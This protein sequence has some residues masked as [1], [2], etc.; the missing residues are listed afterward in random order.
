M[1][2]GRIAGSVKFVIVGLGFL[3]FIGSANAAVLA[4]PTDYVLVYDDLY[5][6]AGTTSNVLKQYLKLRSEGQHVLLLDA[7][8]L[9]AD[10]INKGSTIV[11]AAS[12]FD[13]EQK[14]Q[15]TLDDLSGMDVIILEDE[16]IK[17]QQERERQELIIAIDKVYPFSD[18]NKLMD[19]AE[20]LYDRGMNF[21]VTV[22]PVYENYEL[23][24]FETYIRIL[25]YVGDKGG[26]FFIRYPVENPDGTY[27]TDPR[28]G[29]RR[30]VDEYRKQGLKIIGITLPMDKL[31]TGTE[32]FE[33][34][35]LPLVMV[36]D[37]E[38]KIGSDFDLTKISDMLNRYLIIEG[39]EIND[40]DYFRYFE[41]SSASGSQAVNLSLTD[42]PEKLTDLLNVFKF[43]KMPIGDFNVEDF[44]DRLDNSW[45]AKDPGVQTEEREKSQLEVFKEEE[46]RK[47]R[48]EN[49][50]EEESI[51][52]YDI[53]RFVNKGIMI[54]LILLVLLIVQVLAGRYFELKKYYKD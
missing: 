20:M 43:Y 15:K 54:A 42:D 27:N 34:L 38:N 6:Y 53:S 45:H 4:K 52:G 40:F 7:D 11:I 22:M 36:T 30:A 3:L 49:L 13:T 29:F 31:F 2:N 25:K 47:I 32:V 37:A 23:E 46:M 18:L 21:I 12:S 33:G 35:D 26:S 24:A 41:N 14:M 1:W 39:I 8:K 9:H 44:Y 5:E 51:L 10:Q 17:T 50:Q 16:F 19:T 48:G 28:A